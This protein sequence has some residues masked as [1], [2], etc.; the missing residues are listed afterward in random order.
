MLFCIVQDYDPPSE[1]QVLQRPPKVQQREPFFDL[2]SKQS[3]VPLASEEDLCQFE[4]L[5]FIF[6]SGNKMD[7]VSDSLLQGIASTFGGKKN[8]KFLSQ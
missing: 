3:Q 1:G 8:L 7:H 4:V 5:H 6:V 2:F